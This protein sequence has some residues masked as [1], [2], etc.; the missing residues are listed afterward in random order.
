MRKAVIGG[1]S[2]EQENDFKKILQLVNKG[3]TDPALMLLSSLLY[4]F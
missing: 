3:Q 4:L 1:T 2:M